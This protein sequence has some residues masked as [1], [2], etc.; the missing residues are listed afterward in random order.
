MDVF[1]L[2]DRL[3]GEYQQYV[4]GFVSVREPDVRRFIDQYFAEGHLWPEPLVQINPAFEQASTVDQLVR[5]GALHLECATIFRRRTEPGTSGQPITLHR[6]QADAIQAA[7]TGKSYVLTTGTGSGKSLAY[8]IPIVDYILRRGPGRGIK[9]IVVYPMNALCNSQAEAL[10]RFLHWGYPGGKGPIRFARYTGQ[11]DE[12]RRLAIRANPPDILLTNF[13]MLEL[14]LTRGEEQP[15]VEAAR[16]LEFLVLDELHTY[17]GRQ[18][19]DVAML[20]RRVRE[21]MGAPTMRC[22]GTSATVAGT[23]T[24]EERQAEVAQVAS[25][26]FG[27]GETEVPPTNVIGETVR[28][29]TA[30]AGPTAFELGE[31][32][33]QPADYPTDYASLVRHPVAVWA[34]LAL[35]LQSD[36]RGR[37]ERRPP[38]TLSDAAA[39]LSRLT[40]VDEATCSRHLRALLLAGHHAAN[41]EDG[42]PLF[43]FRLHQ[44]VSR[45]DTVYATPEMPGRRHL[46]AEGQVYVPGDRSKRFF[47]M[48]FCRVCG[49]DHL[50]VSLRPDTMLEPRELDERPEEDGVVAGFVVMDGEGL[51]DP[52]D[53]LSL[54]PEDWTEQR[55]DNLAIRSSARRHVP[56]RIRVAPDGRVLGGNEP[57][58]SDAWFLPAPFRFCFGCGTTYS[59]GRESDFFRMAELST[60]GRSTDTTILSM[61]VVRALREEASLPPEARKMLSFTDNRQDASLQAGHFNDFVQ[62]TRL[63]AAILAAVERAGDGG[64]AHDEI[65]QKVAEALALGFAEY[66]SNP[67]A[68]FAA[69]RQTDEA[70][71]EVVG[72]RVYHD[73]RRGWRINSPNLE[74]VG[75]LRITYDDLD[76]L[77]AAEEVWRPLHPS[78]ARARPAERE[79][80]CQTVLDHL[81]RALAIKVKYLEPSHQE[82]IKQQSFQHLRPPWSFDLEERL[83][84]AAALLT[85]GAR[86]ISRE[87][88]TITTRS[89]LGRYLRRGDVWPSAMRPGERLPADDLTALARDLMKALVVG[90]HVEEVPGNPGAYQLQASVIRWRRGDGQPQHDPARITTAVEASA[91]NEFFARLYQVA[92]AS[93]RQLEAHEH[94]AQ[95][96]ASIREEREEQFGRA[97]LPILY[98]SPTMELGVDIRDLNAVNL[99]NVPPTPANYAQRSGRAGRGGQPALVLTYCSSLSPHDQYYFR[100]PERMVAGAV[101]PPRVDLANEELLRAHVHAVWLAETGQSLYSSV[102]DLL[103]LADPALPL[104][105]EVKAYIERETYQLTAE[106]RC[107]R[108]LDGMADELPPGRAPWYTP[109]WLHRVIQN[110]PLALDRAADRWR[111]LYRTAKLQ[112]DR[113]HQIVA[114]PLR[115]AE[116]RKIAQRL[117]EEAESQLDLLTRARPDVFSDFYS[118][119]YFAAEGFLPGYNFPRLPVTAY[120]PGRQRGKGEEDYLSRARFIAIAEFGPRSVLYHE[121]NRYRVSRVVLP[122]EDGGSR[123]RSAQFCQLCGYA[124]YGDRLEVDLCDRCG[125]LLNATT[126]R[127]FDNLLRLESVSTYRVDR[128]SCDEEERLRLGYEIQTHYRFASREDSSPA[129]REVSYRAGD[130]VVATAT[131]GP[132]TTLWRVNLGWVRRREQH[133]CGFVLDMERGIWSKSDQE[134]GGAED[135]SDPLAAPAQFT[136]VVPFVEDRRNAL[137]LQ[138]AN[139]LEP[140]ALLSLQYALKRGISAR[141]QLE[142]SE[143]AV[144]LLPTA[145]EPRAILFYEAAEGGA[146]VLSRLAEETTAL[147]EVAREALAICHFDP[148]SGA[149]LHRAAQAT[150]DCEAACYDCLLSYANQRYH[151]LLDRKEL[152][153]VLGQ[154]R[155]V[156]AVAGAGGRTR[157]EQRDALARLCG[158]DLEREFLTWLYER[159]RRLPDRAQVPIDAAAARPDFVYDAALTCVYIDGAPHRFPERQRRDNASRTALENRG[160]TV[161]RVAGPETWEKAAC[162]YAWV[163]GVGG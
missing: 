148:A 103:D 30:S 161:V 47:P 152:G 112:Q 4:R 137:I 68:M 64:L 131:Y 125:T 97:E 114:D 122:R 14:I 27:P 51:L 134:P 92:T 140:P 35:G 54:L 93:L 79:R 159:N 60:G 48:A 78:L 65:A 144:E 117:R 71:R 13:V 42:F 130:E 6:H 12:P 10:E 5:S 143:L 36:A 81:R 45:G 135:E 59:S 88:V 2:R 9:A 73:L 94:T 110:A 141:Y 98:C 132:A 126:G 155:G 16:G 101:V 52:L 147:A 46:S 61:A 56:Y 113:Q 34:E 18:G 38:R 151:R 111:H 19:A 102:S 70:L 153:G 20:A 66:A 23:G 136:R 32:L 100:R 104:K 115:T 28:R 17:R 1:A 106:Q 43:A 108:I 57:G 107:R 74:Q 24:R 69:R 96:P 116:E 26:L 3:I 33:R 149:D 84:D 158:S 118:Y 11:E 62:V 160:W 86:R 91:V 157:E 40:A 53:D 76:A 85:E 150:E 124:H 25:R 119:R 37:L 120:I 109:N 163:F 7:R 58:G 145:A 83:R 142:D 123:T 29:A 154:L 21:R 77:C 105:P 138:L 162:D 87:D 72:Y 15:I 90:G 156:T 55:R 49:Q 44:F 128:I 127:R 80:V 75:L 89:L 99:R 22:V 50:V 121:G 146:G 41:P 95:V 8:F 31:A 63:R 139:P 82:R 39:E 67:Q 129:V 133:Q